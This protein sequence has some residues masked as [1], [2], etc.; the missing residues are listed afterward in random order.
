MQELNF[1][2]F[3]W[4]NYLKNYEDLRNVGFVNQQQSLKH[5]YNYGIHEG[6][7]DNSL[8]SN[9]KIPN[10]ESIILFAN[11]RDELGLKEWS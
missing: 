4:E 9:F 8:I 1:S 10:P 11:S 3:N 2:K 5:Y 7:T 6:R